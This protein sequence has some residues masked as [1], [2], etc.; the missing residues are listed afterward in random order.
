[1]KNRSAEGRTADDI[2][3][4]SW[5][6]NAR[7][8]WQ[9]ASITNGDCRR[10]YASEAIHA[11]LPE[12]HQ[13]PTCRPIDKNRYQTRARSLSQFGQATLVVSQSL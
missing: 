1:M 7:L 10:P 2:L 11:H 4:T 5:H 12:A 8:E 3:L 13:S 9:S 6:A